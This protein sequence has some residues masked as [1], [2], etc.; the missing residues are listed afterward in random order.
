[1]SER[2][3]RDP[4]VP[5]SRSL[6]S[7]AS[8]SPK[9][10]LHEEFLSRLQSRLKRTYLPFLCDKLGLL[11]EANTSRHERAPRNGQP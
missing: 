7:L 3:S 2:T 9:P 6:T 5:G 4:F 1:M 8:L 10:K 11:G